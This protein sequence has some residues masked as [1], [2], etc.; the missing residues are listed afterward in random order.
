MFSLIESHTSPISV[1]IEGCFKDSVT[2]FSTT[3]ILPGSSKS[4]SGII[5]TQITPYTTVCFGMPETISGKPHR[6]RIVCLVCSFYI[7]KFSILAITD[8]ISSTDS[9]KLILS[10]DPF[11]ELR[12]KHISQIGE[13]FK[14]NCL[15]LCQ[16]EFHFQ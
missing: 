14:R 13:S 2:C 8:A 9:S 15:P 4:P 16:S 7:N 6:I 3:K 5:H 1:K 10:V 11:E 12:L